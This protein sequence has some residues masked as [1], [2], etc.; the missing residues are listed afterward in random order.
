MEYISEKMEKFE[1]VGAI[2]RV[3][4]T[5]VDIRQMEMPICERHNFWTSST[6]KRDATAEFRFHQSSLFPSNATDLRKR[7]ERLTDASV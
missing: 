3:C 2:Y 1:Q 5:Y 4:L 7:L 6:S